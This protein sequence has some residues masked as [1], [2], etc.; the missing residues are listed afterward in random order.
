MLNWFGRKRELFYVHPCIITVKN[1]YFINK[2]ARCVH[3]KRFFLIYVTAIRYA[4]PQTNAVSVQCHKF[5]KRSSHQKANR[6]APVR[7]ISLRSENSC[8]INK[9]TVIII[10][11][12]EFEYCVR[13]R[14][15]KVIFFL[16]S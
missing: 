5:D 9:T 7:F 4:N 2:D 13:C 3:A 6:K 14:G 12:I 10:D 1:N 8:D 11:V 15:A 16:K